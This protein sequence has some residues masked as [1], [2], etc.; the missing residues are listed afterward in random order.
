MFCQNKAVLPLSLMPNGVMPTVKCGVST[1]LYYREDGDL[2][3]YDAD[4]KTEFN[5]FHLT[6]RTSTTPGV[7]PTDIIYF[8]ITNQSITVDTVKTLLNSYS[9]GNTSIA[10]TIFASAQSPKVNTIHVVV[11]A[12]KSFTITQNGINVRPSFTEIGTIVINTVTYKLYSTASNKYI[13]T[14]SVFI[15][16]LT[17]YVTPTVPV[18]T[19]IMYVGV[20]NMDVTA[21]DTVYG[22]K[23]FTFTGNTPRSFTYT[24]PT[25]YFYVLAPVG[26]TF[27]VTK[28]GVDVTST[29]IDLNSM[30]VRS[31]VFY[32]VYKNLTTPADISSTIYVTVTN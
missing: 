27:T 24:D 3:F 31:G 18:T 13:D 11:P 14:D 15:I 25:G 17:D 10:V 9:Y 1:Y 4:I 6:C 19:T 32:K 22:L 23:P 2:Y 26:K 12:V 8:G 16:G 7:I 5:L 28:N 30:V 29:L 21:D 20:N